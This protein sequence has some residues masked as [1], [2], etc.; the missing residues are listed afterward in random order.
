MMLS[1]SDPNWVIA[2]AAVAQ[3]F[4]TFVLVATTI[5]YAILSHK[6]AKAAE[7]T[8]FATMKL[9]AAEEIKRVWETNKAIILD[10]LRKREPFQDWKDQMTTLADRMGIHY[11]H[12]RRFLLELAKD[13]FVVEGDKGIFELPLP[14]DKNG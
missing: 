1:W 2:A 11:L 3:A 8:A 12:V 9:A 14:P 10:Y 7:A 4:F 5:I 13:G 6:V